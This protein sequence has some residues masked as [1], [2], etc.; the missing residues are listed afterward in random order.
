LFFNS[1][2]R[3]PDSRS[4]HSF[5]EKV[6]QVL[7]DQKDIQMVVCVIPSQ[8]KDVYDSIKK[9]CCLDY[10]IPSQVVTSRLIGDPK[11]GNSAIT[12]IGNTHF[13]TSDIRLFYHS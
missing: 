4:A 12:K 5:A 8:T 7:R 2:E 1:R 10:G 9:I 13:K 3:V 11:K 6:Q